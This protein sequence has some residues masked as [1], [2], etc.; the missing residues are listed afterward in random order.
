MVSPALVE[1]MMRPEFYPIRPPS[2]EL[3]Q[4]H[5]SCVFLAGE[6]VYKIKKPVHF[7]FLD[8][9]TLA[10][11]YRLCHEEVRLNRRLAPDVYLGVVPIVRQSGRFTLGE[12]EGGC[13]QE[14]AVKMR[15]LAESTM[16]DRMVAAGAVGVAQ[17]RAI[18]RRLVAFHVEAGDAKGWAFGSAAAVWR[19]VHGN[20]E[21]LELDFGA[22]VSEAEDVELV[23]YTH[24][25]IESRWCLLN[26]RALCGHVREGHGDLRCEHISLADNMIR[27]IDCVEFNEGLHYSDVASDLAFLVMDLERLGAAELAVE[28]VTAYRNASGDADLPLL[29]PLYKL[30]RALVRAKVASLVSRDAAT[31]PAKR[32]AAAAS[33]RN[34][35]DLALSYARESSPALVVVC[36]MSGSGKSTLAH[37]IADTVGFDLLRS[38]V[39]RK[40][41]AGVAPTTGLSADYRKGIYR[42]E[43]TQQTYATLLAEAFAR[44]HDDVGVIVDATF[45]APAYRAEAREIAARAGVPVLFVECTADEKEIERRLAERESHPDEVS[46]A[47]VAIYRRQRDEFAALDEIPERC[48]LVIDTSGGTGPALALIR[49]RLVDLREASRSGPAQIRPPVPQH[50]GA[51]ER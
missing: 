38:D 4:P 10:R 22:T 26:Q 16:L 11:R 47:G 32:A 2:V 42:E 25:F 14:Y 3:R 1:A 51:A 5:I 18:A 45:G 37:K 8:S 9:S 27:I 41:L 29:I 20:L 12:G 43:F 19:L 39:V 21:E 7:E 15:R 17:I 44:L 36:G 34:Y 46:D 33:V 13:V 49:K 31:A 28:L 35:I 40:R 6:Y 50:A 30:H 24:S 23:R 48:H